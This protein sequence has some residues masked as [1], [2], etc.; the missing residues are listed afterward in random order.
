MEEKK[1]RTAEIIRF[2]LTGG[3]CFLVELAVLILLKG[4][5]GIDTLIATPIAFMISVILN[6]LLC[7]AWVFR[8]AKNRSASAKARFL[9]TSVIG[10][11]LNELLMFLFRLILGEDAVI[12]T[13]GGKTINMY[14]L[15]KCLATLIVMI[16]NYFSKRA[17]LYRKAKQ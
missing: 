7:V 2:A 11:G 1:S 10:L 12:L 16:W 5:L 6:Y 15:N 13:L 4:R 9:I 3:V 14:V 17:V 8:G